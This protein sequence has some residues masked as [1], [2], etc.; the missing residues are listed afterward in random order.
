MLLVN[1]EYPQTYNVDVNVE[2]FNTEYPETFKND[3]RVV[4][5]LK[6]L[7]PET[8]LVNLKR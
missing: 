5:L 1:I 7:N 4:L 3:N 2:L 6:I 8:L